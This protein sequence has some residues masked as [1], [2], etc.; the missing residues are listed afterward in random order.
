MID[1]SQ[2][3][4]LVTHDHCADGLASAM[5]VRDALP[6][7]EVVFAQYNT[8]SLE[9][10][11]ATP[12][13]LFCD[14]TPPR[15]R[16]A[17]FVAAGA[18]VLDHHAHARDIVELFGERGHFADELEWPGVSGACLAYQAI[19]LEFHPQ[20]RRNTVR[21]FARLVGIRDTWQKE[22]PDWDHANDLHA[23]LMGLPRDYWLRAD[24]RGIAN[25]MSVD[26]FELGK[27]WRAQRRVVV[28][29]ICGSGS[30]G[31]VDPAGREWAVFPDA[32]G[33]T[34]DVAEASRLFGIPVT[35]GW[36]QTVTYGQLRTVLSLRSDGAAGNPLDV[37][38]LC[39]RFGGGGHTRAAGCTLDESDP[40]VAVRRVMGEAT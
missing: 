32:R 26:S 15:A 31:L 7:A 12:G 36:F 6:H 9:D 27:L 14:I 2:V 39:K 5:I 35:C 28:A 21:E 13:L 19:W 30:L 34:S 20:D 3:T 18:I 11:P 22:S 38:A 25:A 33:H 29:D 40:L 23:A 24:G 8:P 37:G 4:K 16:A 1:V 10:L 17:E